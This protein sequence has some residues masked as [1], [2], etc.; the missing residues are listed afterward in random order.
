VVRFVAYCRRVVWVLP[1]DEGS[2]LEEIVQPDPALVQFSEEE[3][4]EVWAGMF[5]S[6]EEFELGV[7]QA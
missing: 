7:V 3:L 6:E 1:E 4:E 2:E 5:D